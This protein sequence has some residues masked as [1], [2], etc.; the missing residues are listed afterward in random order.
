MT[1]NDETMMNDLRRV[2]DA[3]DG[4]R[5]ASTEAAKAAFAWRTVDVELAELTF[6]SRVDEPEVAVRSGATDVRRL[7]F[8]SDSVTIELETGPDDDL[9]G[10]VIPPAVATIKLIEASGETL[11]T[12]DSD[13]LGVFTSPNSRRPRSVWNAERMTVPGRSGLPGSS[14]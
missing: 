1:T 14:P 2:L 8:T 6:D 4:P 3:V 9:I 7:A 10:Q 5:A 12:I 11:A 13:A